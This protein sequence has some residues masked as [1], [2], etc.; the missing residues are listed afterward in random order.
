[1]SKVLKNTVAAT[2]AIA[3]IGGSFA[4]GVGAVALMPQL[5]V[6]HQ[7]SLSLT[8]IKISAKAALL[9]DVRS[10]K[11]LYQKNANLELPL[12]SLTKL[13][14]A[15]TVL[16][17]REP[18][19]VVQITADS[20]RQEGDSGLRP[21]DAFLL[22]DLLRLGL[23]ASSNDAIAA[24][25]ASLG[26]DYI[27]QMNV[28]AQELGL[29]KTRFLNPTGLDINANTAGAF[30]SAYDVARL[31]AA[32][33]KEH[34]ALFEET[35]RAEVSVPQ[36]AG[37]LVAA[38]TAA[39][40]LNIPGLIGGKTG[41]T[42]LAGGNLVAAFDLEVGRPVIAVVLGSTREGRFTDIRTLIEAARAAQ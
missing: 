15:Q 14:A 33:F 10:G 1:M 9:L 3:S 40:L 31:A 5:V 6:P 23:V 38:A 18:T 37:S 26:T 27:T 19:S 25:A 28:A 42:D 12:A 41:F 34:P 7:G 20:L 21:G 22:E 4:L 11:V 17:V 2:L 36:G 39:P 13:M 8:N 16:S 35:V 29:T 30:G 32:F 24:A